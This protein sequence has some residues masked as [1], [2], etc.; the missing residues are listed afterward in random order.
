MYWFQQ[1]VGALRMYRGTVLPRAAMHQ[2]DLYRRAVSVCL[3]VRHVRVLYHILRLFTDSHTLLFF[4]YKTL[5]QYSNRD[6]LTGVS[7]AGV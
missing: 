2:R 1:A 7:N 5:L 4:P 6:L 3:S